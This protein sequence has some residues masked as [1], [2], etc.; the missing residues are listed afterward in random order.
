MF[1]RIL[2]IGK[3]YGTIRYIWVP[4]PWGGEK[5]V[6]HHVTYFHLGVVMIGLQGWVEGVPMRWRRGCLH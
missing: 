6:K 1:D 4:V 5:E 3:L 2:T